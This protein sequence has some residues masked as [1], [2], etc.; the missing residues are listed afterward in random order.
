MLY[1]P[2]IVF[3]LNYFNMATNYEIAPRILPYTTILP[4]PP[5]KLNENELFLN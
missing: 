4:Y 1:Y 3:K 2:I 5:F